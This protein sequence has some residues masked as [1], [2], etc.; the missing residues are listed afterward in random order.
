MREIAID[1]LQ[2]APFSLF[3]KDWMALTA[4]NESNG[5]NTMTIAWGHLGSLWDRDSQS[6]VLPTVTCYSRPSRYTKEFLDREDLFTIS[7]FPK[8][9]RKALG[10]LGNHSGRDENKVEKVGLTPVFAYGTTYF[11]EADLVFVCRKLYSSELK[12]EGFVEKS[13]VDFNYP[14]KDFH[15]M[16]VGEVLKVLIR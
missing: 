16:Y 5:Y 4:G 14:K 2:V 1:E 3:G 15:T 13:L 8:E 6:N 7:H 11:A 9:Y 10:Y 12:E